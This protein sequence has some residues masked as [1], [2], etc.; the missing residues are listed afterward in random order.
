[1]VRYTRFGPNHGL[2]GTEIIMV[3]PDLVARDEAMHP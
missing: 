3:H 1:M 2:G